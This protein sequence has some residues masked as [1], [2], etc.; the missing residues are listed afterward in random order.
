MN[1]LLVLA[2]GAILALAG[3]GVPVTAGLV[4]AGLT[5]AVAI[6]HADVTMLGWYLCQRGNQAA[7]NGS[8]SPATP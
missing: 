3:C 4:G 1:R 6:T 5:A 7:C 2:I 8:E